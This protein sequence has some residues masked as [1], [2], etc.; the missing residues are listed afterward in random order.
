M[1]ALFVVGA[2]LLGIGIAIKRADERRCNF[3]NVTETEETP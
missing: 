2:V 3:A 1:T